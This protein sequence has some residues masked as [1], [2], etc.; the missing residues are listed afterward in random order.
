MA[1][2]LPCRITKALCAD[3]HA[4]T[5]HHITSQLVTWMCRFLQS[6]FQTCLREG[7]KEML[8]DVD[9]V[10]EGVG[11]T[12]SCRDGDLGRRRLHAAAPASRHSL[13]QL[14]LEQLQQVQAPQLIRAGQLHVQAS[15]CC[16]STTALHQLL[17][18]H[19]GPRLACHPGSLS[20][21]CRRN[22]AL[23]Q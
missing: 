19:N 3:V 10:G 23:C 14:A 11:V 6:N 21:V 9:G 5:L 16:S 13:H 12:V 1:A 15:C 20:P 18:R 22:V 7:L 2:R 4:L 8:V 17:P